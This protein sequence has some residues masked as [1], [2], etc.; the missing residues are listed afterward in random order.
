[1]ANIVTRFISF[2]EQLEAICKLENIG[3][4]DFTFIANSK[5]ENGKR[6]DIKLE[7]IFPMEL[8]EKYG[9]DKNYNIGNKLEK[10][11]RAILGKADYPLLTNEEKNKLKKFGIYATNITKL[12]GVLEKIQMIYESENLE[13][14]NFNM[15]PPDKKISHILPSELI[16]KYKLDGEYIIGHNINRARNIYIGNIRDD[17]VTEEDIKGL[18][19]L[20]IIEKET[21]VERYIRILDTLE[22]AGISLSEILKVPK[23]TILSDV[24]PKELLNI[25]NLNGNYDLESAKEYAKRAGE[26]GSNRPI[27]REEMQRLKE[28][29][30]VRKKRGQ[31]YNKEQEQ[32]NLITSRDEIK[33]TFIDTRNALNYNQK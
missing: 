5:D 20:G 10:A 9:L 30:I 28:L 32:Q 18:E 8:I 19:S 7:D 25:Y 22:S 33:R 15:I 31:L 16:T 27:T 14:I 1:M 24:V 3:I 26:K 2:L 12:I 4:I 17:K 13:N 29:G 21:S 11:K 23:G 6:R